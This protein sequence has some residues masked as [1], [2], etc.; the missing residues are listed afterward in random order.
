MVLEK[1]PDTEPNQEHTTSSADLTTCPP[2]TKDTAI[3]DYSVPAQVL[4][5]S[6]QQ[7]EGTAN[8]ERKHDTTH[9]HVCMRT[10]PSKAEEKREI[11]L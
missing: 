5:R 10:L 6:D 2:L 3:E 9:T 8:A 1:W 7:A 4:Q 11:T